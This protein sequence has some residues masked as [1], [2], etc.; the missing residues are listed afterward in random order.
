MILNQI[1]KL[2]LQVLPLQGAMTP[3]SSWI[4]YE[5]FSF[6]SLSALCLAGSTRLLLI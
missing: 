5:M 4:S 6:N 1:C 2:G 3:D